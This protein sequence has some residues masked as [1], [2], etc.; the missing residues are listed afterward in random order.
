MEKGLEQVGDV[1]NSPSHYTKGKIE[2]ID[3]IIDQNMNYLTASACKYLCRWEHKHKG[4]GQ[5]EGVRKA[6]LF[7]EELL[8]DLLK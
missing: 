6:R 7:I 8:E 4:D 2:V 3:F 1:V 5:I